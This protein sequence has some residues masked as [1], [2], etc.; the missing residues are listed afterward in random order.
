VANSSQAEPIITRGAGDIFHDLI[1][2]KPAGEDRPAYFE[3]AQ[4][5]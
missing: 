2:A 3:V 5:L 4:S 1:K